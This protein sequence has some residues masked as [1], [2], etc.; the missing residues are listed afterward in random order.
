MGSAITFSCGTLHEARAVTAGNR[1]ILVGFFHGA[2]DEA[3]RCDYALS[4]GKKLHTN[5]FTPKMRQYPGVAQ[6]RDFYKEWYEQNVRFTDAPP[7]AG[8]I[9]TKGKG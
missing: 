3:F 7:F 5:D 6:G 4:K 1:F 2:Q 9:D 8:K